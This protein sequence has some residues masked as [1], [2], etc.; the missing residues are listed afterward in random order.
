M[1]RSSCRRFR[2]L[3]LFVQD[4]SLNTRDVV[5]LTA[6]S[7]SC[8]SCREYRGEIIQIT[9]AIQATGYENDGSPGFSTRVAREV[10]RQR[11]QPLAGLRPG[12][13]GALFAFLAV[14]SIVQ[15]VTASP[16]S[17]VPPAGSAAERRA[18]T[19]LQGEGPM[20]FELFDTPSRMVKDPEPLDV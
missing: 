1:F 3:S 10:I 6:H 20:R 8:K 15:I 9:A 2:R 11:T 5:F 14:G 13:V 7:E 17:A 16:T 4:S 19:P 12:L 18:I